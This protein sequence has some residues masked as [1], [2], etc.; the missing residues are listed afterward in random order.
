MG[1]L[2]VI[3]HLLSSTSVALGIVRK[4]RQDFAAACIFVRFAIS[5]LNDERV[6]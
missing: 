5:F 1:R 2:E 3:T 4:L 6:G